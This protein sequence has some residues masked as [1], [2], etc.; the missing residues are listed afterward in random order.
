MD[1]QPSPRKDQDAESQEDG[2]QPIRPADDDQQ[3]ILIR[4]LDRLETTHFSNSQG[5]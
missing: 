4:K 3:P 2:P 1:I 5:A